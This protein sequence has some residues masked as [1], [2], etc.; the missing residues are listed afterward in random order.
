MPQ[1]LQQEQIDAEFGAASSIEDFDIGAHRF[2]YTRLSPSDFEW[3]VYALY[4]ADLEKG[5]TLSYDNVRVLMEGAD[6]GRDL[7]L[8]KDQKSVGVVQCKRY[9]KAISLPEIFRELFKFFLFAQLD[10]ALVPEPRDFRYT[11]VV[12]SDPMETVADLFMESKRV[13]QEYRAKLPGY[14]AEVIEEYASFKNMTAEALQPTIEGYLGA[15]RYEL[16]R[17][18]DLDAR[19]ERTYHWL[20]LRRSS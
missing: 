17:P 8:Y 10:P 16:V 2:P 14:L 6:R 3:L 19:V 4:R 20:R 18:R 1:F 13:I 5:T 11:L 12:A 9:E 15:F 7:V